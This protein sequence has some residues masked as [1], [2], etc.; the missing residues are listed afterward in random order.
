[1]DTIVVPNQDTRA[2]YYPER[3]YYFF[4]NEMENDWQVSTSSD[5]EL[6][7]RQQGFNHRGVDGEMPE[8]KTE[9][10]RIQN[11]HRI[12]HAGPLA[13][14]EPGVTVQNGRKILVTRG[15]K[16]IEPAAGKFPTI[17]IF[18]DGLLRDQRVYFEGWVKVAIEALRARS[19]RNGQALVLAGPRACGKSFL[20]HN[21]I[22]PLLGG[23]SVNPHL[24]LSGATS[25]NSSLTENEHWLIEDEGTS[26]DGSS[27]RKDMAASIKQATSND[28]V[29]HHAKGKDLQT[30]NVF[31]R[32]TISCN[33]EAKHIRIL[34]SMDSSL[35]DKIIILK[36]T[37]EE[38][39]M[40]TETVAE[41]DALVSTIR[42]ELPAFTHHLIHTFKI[43]DDLRDSRFG[44][45]AYKSPETLE[46][47]DAMEPETRLL[48]LIDEVFAGR[49][50]PWEGKSAK[51]ERELTDPGSP[52]QR[53]AGKLL[54]YPNS[55]GTYLKKLAE[56]EK[57]ARRISSRRLD[58]HQVF[59]IEKFP[60]LD[61][62]DPR[63]PAGTPRTDALTG[64]L[65]RAQTNLQKS[66]VMTVK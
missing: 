22:T 42:E 36:A 18:L 14:F 5:M 16:L 25:F 59:K 15:P 50:V 7:L 58:G 44:I 19:I 62:D 21:I 64:E 23:R 57:Y 43:P 10:L 65:K 60:E 56:K 37:R 33:E 40:K 29:E 28:A 32:L 26:Q 12:S 39:P 52:V 41:R 11:E 24:Y 66:L 55:C 45:K 17:S 34:P 31:R 1:M 46:I 20:Q 30:V 27:S 2:Y 53:Q 51:L 13:G 49:N 48:E 35:E 6:R 47:M 63:R 54:K 9:L 38:M 61:T 4:Y 8:T 3:N